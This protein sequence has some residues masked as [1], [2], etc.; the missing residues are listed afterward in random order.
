MQTN[1]V[2]D[3]Y[4]PYYVVMEPI[5]KNSPAALMQSLANGARDGA[6]LVLLARCGAQARDVVPGL[7]AHLAGVEDPR[8]R[9]RCF[10]ALGA[11]LED[12]EG[13]AARAAV[14]LLGN[15]LGD[16]FYSRMRPKIANTLLRIGF[17]ARLVITPLVDT[18]RAAK[19]NSV[20]G[21]VKKTLFWLT[22]RCWVDERADNQRLIFEVLRGFS[23]AYQ[24]WMLQA[25]LAVQPGGNSVRADAEQLLRNIQNTGRRWSGRLIEPYTDE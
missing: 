4:A 18:L 14:R 2:G 7:L 20:R 6:I 15:A 5:A 25:V 9:A 3:G 22:W 8:W 1:F 21:S 13:A 23:R 24:E 10:D 11:I 17:E 19:L 12:V 16:P